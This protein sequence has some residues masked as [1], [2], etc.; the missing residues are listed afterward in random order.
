MKTSSRKALLTGCAALGIA[1]ISGCA[2]STTSG[3]A[4]GSASASVGA[5]TPEM[6]ASGRALFTGAGRCGVCHAPTGRGG[7]LGPNLT[8][9]DWI[10]V[11]TSMDV[12]QQIAV[13]IRDGISE[14]RQFPAPM[15]AQGGGSLT[16]VQIQ[17]L[18]AFVAQM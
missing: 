6:I 18:A 3:A 9:D 7:S 15:P 11:D 4:E 5:A 12:R 10:W 8:D 17:A 14:P 16:E 13:I 1:L 2:A